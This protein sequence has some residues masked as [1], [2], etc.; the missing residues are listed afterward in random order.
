MS[1][2]NYEYCDEILLHYCETDIDLYN[3]LK[4]LNKYYYSIINANDNYKSWISLLNVRL[5]HDKNVLFVKACRGGNIVICNYL[6]NK[7]NDINI[8][9]H[10]EW[11]FRCSCE[12]GHLKV[13]KWLVDL[14][15]QNKF[16]CVDIHTNSD[17]AFRWSCTNGHLEVCKWL[18][19]LSLQENEYAFRYSC[20]YAD[21]EVAKWLVGLSL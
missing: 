1:I 12:F 5:S 14:N 6:L 10:N 7:F 15:S 21:L 2:F 4:C 8:H 19:N 18:I 20:I 11:A 13:S 3:I 17:Y 9:A 16:T